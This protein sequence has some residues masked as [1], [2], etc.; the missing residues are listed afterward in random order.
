MRRKHNPHVALLSLLLLA[1]LVTWICGGCSN[2]TDADPAV[3]TTVESSRFA[4]EVHKAGKLDFVTVITDKDTGASYL[5]YK[6]GYGG[7]LTK[8]DGIDKTGTTEGG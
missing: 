4:I 8:L 5:F 1:L 3:E 6:S 2:D 7:G